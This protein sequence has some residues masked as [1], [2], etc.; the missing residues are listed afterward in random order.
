LPALI[1]R[2]IA[3]TSEAAARSRAQQDVAAALKRLAPVGKAVAAGACPGERLRAERATDIALFERGQTPAGGSGLDLAI[4]A[5]IAT[6]AGA[7]LVLH[8]PD[9][10]PLDG[11]EAILSLPSGEG[12]S[13]DVV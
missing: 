11:F 3:R 10:G 2:L 13:K 7:R 12:V 6:G 5:G 1:Q 8:S 9:P 4:A